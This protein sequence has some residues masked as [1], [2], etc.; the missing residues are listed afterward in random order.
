MMFFAKK[1]ARLFTFLECVRKAPLSLTSGVSEVFRVFRHF[2]SPKM[3]KNRKKVVFV[4]A[5]FRSKV[6]K[7][8]F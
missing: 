2:D 1:Y 4:Y 6:T 8:H 3:A 7:S 5:N